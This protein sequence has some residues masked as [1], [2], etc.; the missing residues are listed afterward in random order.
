[1]LRLRQLPSESRRAFVVDRTGIRTETGFSSRQHLSGRALYGE[2][3]KKTNSPL[4]RVHSA[5]SL[6]RSTILRLLLRH[7]FESSG[8]LFILDLHSLYL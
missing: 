1:M 3:A 4:L 8:A 5:R 2:A 7:N 6:K